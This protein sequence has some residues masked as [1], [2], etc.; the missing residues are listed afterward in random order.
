VWGRICAL[1][2]LFLTYA[3]VPLVFDLV[4]W[5]QF[6]RSGSARS[7]LSSICACSLGFYDLVFLE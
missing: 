4:F 1:P 7:F 6:G 2:F 5:N 3:Y